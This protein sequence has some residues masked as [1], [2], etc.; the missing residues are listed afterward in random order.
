MPF[1]L[2]E[3]KTQPAVNSFYSSGAEKTEA[4]GKAGWILKAENQPR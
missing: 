2:D 1:I 3:N 4:M